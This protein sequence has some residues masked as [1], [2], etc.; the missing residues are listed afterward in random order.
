MGLQRRHRRVCCRSWGQVDC[1]PSVASN[2][3]HT[4]HTGAGMNAASCSLDTECGGCEVC[5]CMWQQWC[6]GGIVSCFTLRLTT[7]RFLLTLCVARA[8]CLR[9]PHGS[10]RAQW[11]AAV[12]GARLTNWITCRGCSRLQHHAASCS[13]VTAGKMERHALLTTQRG[14]SGDSVDIQ[15]ISR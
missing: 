3:H 6:R 1:A 2:I 9:A 13:I 15:H 8:P 14:T 10:S 12:L 5:W 7:A 4:P 11:P